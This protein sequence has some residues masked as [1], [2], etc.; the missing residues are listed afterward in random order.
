MRR[1]RGTAF[2]EGNKNH[3]DGENHGD[4]VIPFLSEIGS[5]RTVP[6]IHCRP[7]APPNWVEFLGF[8]R[9]STFSGGAKTERNA[10]LCVQ[11]RQPGG[12]SIA[13]YIININYISL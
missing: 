2:A 13:L 5:F 8:R 9:I 4:C 12:A 7:S 6:M 11:A 3:V 1:I 10:Y